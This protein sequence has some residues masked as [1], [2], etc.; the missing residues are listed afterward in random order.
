MAYAEIRKDGSGFF[1]IIGSGIGDF[2]FAMESEAIRIAT[3]INEA[4]DA[5]FRKAKDRLLDDIEAAQ[6]N[7]TAAMRA[8]AF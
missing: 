1:H 5:G 6:N 2:E 7:L 4:Y 3:A 8:A